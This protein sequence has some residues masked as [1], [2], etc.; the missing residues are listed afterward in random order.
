LRQKAEISQE[1]L[2]GR[3]GLS[4]NSIGSVERGEFEVGVESLS[5][6]AGA[7]GISLAEFFA[8]FRQVRRAGPAHEPDRG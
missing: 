3:A 4:R 8:P 7:L 5:R 2:G 1:E 6:I